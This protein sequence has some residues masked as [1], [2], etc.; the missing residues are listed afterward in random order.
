MDHNVFDG[1][2]GR[3]FPVRRPPLMPGE[4]DRPFSARHFNEDPYYFA[5]GGHGIKRPFSMMV[6][7]QFNFP[8]HIVCLA[9]LF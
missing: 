8:N 9:V 7:K 3:G 1:G 4:F 6:G 2:R 5:D